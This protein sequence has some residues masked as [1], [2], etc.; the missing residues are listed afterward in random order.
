[1]SY[2]DNIIGAPVS[3]K[4]V[5]KALNVD[6]TNDL[7]KLCTHEYINM[8]SKYKPVNN[9]LKFVKDTVNS[10]GNT[11]SEATEGKGW[12]L[13]EIDRAG[14]DGRAI[15]FP[16]ITSMAS[17]DTTDTAPQY[18]KPAGGET[19]PYRL[20]DF[21]GY[22]DGAVAPMRVI[23]NTKQNEIGK[24]WSCNIEVV[25]P[26]DYEAFDSSYDPK[27]CYSWNDI[28]DILQAEKV[29]PAVLVY[30]KTKKMK[31][32]YVG[33]SAIGAGD[34]VVKFKLGDGS[35][36]SEGGMGFV[37]NSGDVLEMYVC[38]TEY[39]DSEVYD[40]FRNAYRLSS[41][42]N[43][44]TL[45]LTS[46]KTLTNRNFIVHGSGFDYS[47]DT[48]LGTRYIKTSD[49]DI[50]SGSKLLKLNAGGIIWKAAEVDLSAVTLTG[51]YIWVW[52]NIIGADSDETSS[53]YSSTRYELPVNPASDK[54]Y[55]LKDF[56]SVFYLTQQ[57]AEEGD[58]PVTLEGILIPDTVNYGSAMFAG[59]V[60]KVEVRV[61]V[62]LNFTS[63]NYRMMQ[64][65]QDDV[66]YTETFE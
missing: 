54:V 51:G 63:D 28:L 64:V 58:E 34:N 60:K 16:T 62:S 22:Y 53:S 4:D 21:A 12:W 55:S 27:H 56:T 49:D 5:Q 18:V 2:S 42:T 47:I 65:L 36:Y 25:D 31:Y 1:M 24:E 30:N 45:T 20:T 44:V 33:H 19:S 66:I 39:D 46:D 17:C 3:I 8:W 11:W 61:G 6:E 7:S 15:Y 14:R 23:I 57:N 52:I 50:V 9:T 32:F 40:D 59:K 37:S 41:M 10:D 35:P 43:H 26:D 29:Y 48:S 38:A 13:G